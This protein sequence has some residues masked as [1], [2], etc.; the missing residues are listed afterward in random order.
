MWLKLSHC[1]RVT[2]WDLP[3]TALSDQNFVSFPCVTSPSPVNIF[4]WSTND[5]SLS[6]PVWVLLQYSARWEITIVTT[7]DKKPYFLLEL[8]SVENRER[9]LLCRFVL[10]HLCTSQNTKQLKWQMP[11][12]CAPQHSAGETSSSDTVWTDIFRG[13]KICHSGFLQNAITKV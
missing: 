13:G 9:E 6:F 8:Y 4:T 7:A 1:Q 12:N 5:K 3:S 2:D 10:G 11:G